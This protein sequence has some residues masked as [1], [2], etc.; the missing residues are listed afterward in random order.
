MV[1][2]SDARSHL[3]T[4][5]VLGENN[6]ATIDMATSKIEKATSTLTHAGYADKKGTALSNVLTISILTYSRLLTD[7]TASLEIVA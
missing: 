2:S 6:N 3:S 7:H 1:A 5:T 4:G